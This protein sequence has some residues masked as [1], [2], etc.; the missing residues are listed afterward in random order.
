MKLLRKAKQSMLVLLFAVLAA[1]FAIAGCA[2][3]GSDKTA[4]TSITITTSGVALT[5]GTY[6]ITAE[7]QPAE[8]DQDYTV[9]LKETYTGISVDGKSVV[10]SEDAVH[11]SS[12]TV[13]VTAAA[14]TAITGEKSFIVDNPP[15]VPGVAITNGS[16]FVDITDGTTAY[17]ILYDVSPKGTPVTISLKEEVEGVELAADG[18]VTIDPMI[19]NKQTFLAVATAEVDG[20][21]LTD[22]KQFTIVN[23]VYRPI[24]TEE[25]LRAL[26]VDAATSSA[27]LNNFYCLT[28]DITLTGNWYQF[29]G[30]TDDSSVIHGY[31]GTFDGKG[32]AIRNFNYENAGWNAGFFWSI[33][34][35]GKVCNLALYGS[36]TSAG[37]CCG[38][39]S[40]Y[41]FGTIEN[42]FVDVDI[43]QTHASQWC[44]ALYAASRDSANGSKVIHCLSVG[45]VVCT[46]GNSGLIGSVNYD[47]ETVFTKS[48]GL[49]GTVAAVVGETQAQGVPGYAE[50]LS[51]L[52]LQNAAT[53]EGWDTDI[54][55]IKNGTYPLLKNADF[56]EPELPDYPDSTITNTTT[57]TEVDYANEDERT[58]TVTY[59]AEPAGTEV[60]FSL[61]EEVEGVSVDPETGV[62]TITSE[63]NN[64]A[65]F[66]VN[67]QAKENPFSSDSATVTV[68]NETVKE[69]STAEQLMRL[70]GATDVLYNNYKLTADI[71]LTE[72]FKPIGN[73]IGAY[74]V[75]DGYKGTFDGNGYTISN[76][77]MTST[78]WNAGFFWCIASEGVVKNLKL[79]GGDSG[80][81]TIIGGALAG[82]LWGT[83]E[84]C[85]VDVDVTSNHA[86]QPSGG[87]VGTADGEYVIRNCIYT[88]TAKCQDPASANG[89]GFI[90]SGP[91]EI[92]DGDGNVIG[93]LI[94]SYALATGVDAIV[95][96]AKV[97][98]EEGAYLKSLAELRSAATYA[99]WDDG[100]WYIS[101]GNFPEL[102]YPGFEEPETNYAVYITN[103]DTELDYKAGDTSVQIECF[104]LP[105]DGQVVYGLKEEVRGVSISDTGLV[106]IE[107]NVANKARFTVVVTLGG[108]S[109]EMTFT[110]LNDNVVYVYDQEDLAAIG[111]N[112]YGTYILM[113]D[114]ELTGTWTPLGWVDGAS[115]SDQTNAFQGTLDGNG[116][117]ISGMNVTM[118]WNAGF[119]WIIGEEGLVKNLGLV[120]SVKSSCGGAFTGNMYGTLEN[121][122][123]DVDV[124][125]HAD[126]STQW[127]GTLVGGI[128]GSATV[129]NCYAIGQ[130]TG[131]ASSA[132]GA[133][134][135]GSGSKNSI[136]GS[137]V[138]DTSVDAIVGYARVGDETDPATDV[139]KTDA[140]LKD[141]ATFADWDDSIWNFAEG[142][143]PSLREGCTAAAEE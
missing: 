143:Y 43:T 3:S 81:V 117:T 105:A 111:E 75:D 49:R 11:E 110:V 12:F 6:E 33:A 102:R 35:E 47:V 136:V 9:S 39:I 48:F 44:G 19:D 132:N 104:K 30:Y 60:T 66:T 126:S 32:Y 71:V 120:G 53:Y 77:N 82:S 76:F 57:V 18:T 112:L 63:V 99:E 61:E 51:E 80:V 24:S 36:L 124:S 103:T 108:R 98:D 7:V 83:I 14:D 72:N 84:N 68:T 4:P 69:I 54:W 119:I 138:L 118:S 58:F 97:A 64:Q 67:I 62:V 65:T 70:S 25:E 129:R 128:F 134:L 116:Y 101:E 38:A 8:A 122:W 2:T 46:S 15:P 40:G 16:L 106:T 115:A 109:D 86:T 74:N 125:L 88:G 91:Y 89:S 50:L 55:F 27:N 21:T 28:N 59:T 131:N 52:Q 26:W 140:E 22:E 5:P 20:V 41:M 139:A 37:G 133:G 121:C 95:G 127:V 87:I 114:I 85:F 29:M 17:Q 45:N 141:P 56:E 13:V 96:A 90:G 31:A 34:P 94:D 137:F 93:G 78:G 79:V 1:L 113:N 135:I 73:G 123:A 92:L 107:G 23:E 142:E 100:V 10:I 42:L 130:G